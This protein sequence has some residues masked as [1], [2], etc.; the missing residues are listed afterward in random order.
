MR[1]GNLRAFED[2]YEEWSDSVYRYLVH[3]VGSPSV[4]EDLFQETWMRALERQGQLKAEERFGPWILRI[5]RNQAL[6]YQRRSRNKLQVWILSNLVSREESKG[7]DLVARSPGKD[8]TP[9]ENAVRTQQRE[10]LQEAMGELEPTTQEMLQLRYFEELT[11][12]EVAEVLDVP[13]G[14]VCSR[15]HRA[16]KAIRER[17]KSRGFSK[18]NEI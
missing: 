4:A 8:P 14:T 1:N 10:I 5:A 18:L 17:L 9:R 11:L 3:F 15:I 13:L 2:Y 7:E 6:N 16:L 12:S